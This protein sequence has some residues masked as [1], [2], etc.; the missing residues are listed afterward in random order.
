MTQ[1]PSTGMSLVI[2][3]KG[4]PVDW[5]LPVRNTL[6]EMDRDVIVLN[7]RDFAQDVSNSFAT[8]RYTMGLLSA[9]AALALLVA[10]FG[11]YSVI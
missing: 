11:I 8:R 10:S 1:W 6:R 9:F 3:G 4:R 7:I 2:R 5:I